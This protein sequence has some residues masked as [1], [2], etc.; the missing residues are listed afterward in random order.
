MDSQTFNAKRIQR[1]IAYCFYRQFRQRQDP[2]A[3][4]NPC[5]SITFRDAS[6]SYC[7]LNSGVVLP[8][9]LMLLALIV[10]LTIQTQTIT[11][12]RLAKEQRTTELTRL[13]IIA[14]DAVWQTLASLP[15]KHDSLHTQTNADWAQ[16][17]EEHLPDGTLLKVQVK[18]ALSRFNI[19]NLG[20]SSLTSGVARLPEMIVADLLAGTDCPEPPA[21]AKKL[22]RRYS[23]LSDGGKPPPIQSPAE[24][25][26]LVSNTSPE[27]LLAFFTILP[28]SKEGLTPVNVNSAPLPVLIGVLGPTRSLTAQA[29]AESRDSKPLTDLRHFPFYNAIQASESYL[30]VHS[31]FFTIEAEAGHTE[32]IVRIWALV[33]RDSANHWQVRHWVCR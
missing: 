7:N 12:G 13:R 3:T 31:S 20:I 5:Y 6:Q 14:S 17:K 28:V 10:T 15:D 19:N 25:F 32:A 4:A 18:D 23:D 27:Q 21:M 30:T 24:F 9:V 22:R 33:E 1:R 11:R 16:P 8:A 2:A 26:R 29:L